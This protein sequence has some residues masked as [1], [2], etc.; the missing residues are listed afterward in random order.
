MLTILS[1]SCLLRSSN[2]N[3][4]NPLGGTSEDCNGQKLVS[5]YSK[6]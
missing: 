6:G 2:Y 5:V 1:L 4:H 3:E